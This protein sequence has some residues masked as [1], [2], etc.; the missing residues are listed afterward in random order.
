[1]PQMTIREAIR[2]G[3]QELLDED[4]NVFLMGEDI[5]AYG[6]SYAVT[7][8]F[9][10]RYGEERVRDTP[11]SESVIVG[12][13]VGAAMNGARPI[14]EL[15]TINFSLVAMDQIVNHAAKIFYMFGGQQPVPLVIRTVTGGGAMLGP[16][17]SQSF[18]G[19]YAN[20]PG[21]KVACPAFPADA[22]GL[23]LASVRDN[24]PVLF[25]EHQG[26]YRIKGEV[27]EGKY[28]VP[29]GKSNIVRRGKDITLVAYSRSVHVA[30]DAAEQL[31]GEGLDAEVIDLR[32]LRPLDL[33]PV[34]ESVRKTNRACVIEE[35]WR[36]GAFGAHVVGEIQHQCF[37]DLDGPVLRV[38]SEDV[39]FP[40]NR[41]LE[42]AAMPQPDRVVSAVLSIV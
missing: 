15:M 28:E 33:D 10:D 42:Q 6:G 35:G 32:C 20:V 13:G 5:G 29:L 34:F 18:E 2:S 8:G 40:Y 26:L 7:S 21:L 19:W 9:L 30:L 41:N 17:H 12:A 36:T 25:V 11:I 27:P 39:S 1:M 23:L 37:D 31:A 3:L 14:V 22:K 24:N 16:T 4:P 38:A